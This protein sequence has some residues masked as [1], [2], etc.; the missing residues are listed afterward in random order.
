MEEVTVKGIRRALKDALEVKRSSE[1]I[2][3]ALSLEDIDAIPNVTIAEALVPVAGCQR[4][5]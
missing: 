4:Y 3:E 5:P 1:H 2:V